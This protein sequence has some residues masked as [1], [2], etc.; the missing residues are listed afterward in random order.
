MRNLAMM[1]APISTRHDATP[2]FDIPRRGASA[3][4]ATTENAP[5]AEAV[6]TAETVSKRV[7]ANRCNDR[8]S[9]WNKTADGKIR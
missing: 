7:E 6:P 3:I 4:S 5:T 2:F 8:I 9:E 1:A